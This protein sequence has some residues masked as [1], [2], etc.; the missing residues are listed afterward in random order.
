MFHALAGPPI[1]SKDENTTLTRHCLV[2]VPVRRPAISF[3]ITSR[4]L[5]NQK[6]VYERGLFISTFEIYSVRS[7]SG[8]PNWRRIPRSS[9]SLSFSGRTF[10]RTD[11]CSDRSALTIRV[12]REIMRLCPNWFNK[13][14]KIP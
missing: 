7:L 2:F 14:G 10:S 5:A 1:G 12:S 9:R 3:T 11:R 4:S 6:D 13:R 8:I